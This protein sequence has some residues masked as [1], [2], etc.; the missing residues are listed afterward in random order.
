[1]I[2]DEEI[3]GFASGRNVLLAEDNEINAQIARSQLEP[4][5]FNVVW[6]ENGKEAYDIFIESEPHYFSAFVTDL[7]MPVMD[8]NEAAKKVRESSRDDSGLP[9]LGITANTFYEDMATSANTGINE[10]IV[11]PYK[12]RDIL[13][14]LY[15]SV[16]KYE[17]TDVSDDRSR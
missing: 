16:M 1:M 2:T 15:K 5:G 9:I 8:G 11:K 10:V 12:K 6:A 4:A 7:M 13:E 17:G 3:T 14:W